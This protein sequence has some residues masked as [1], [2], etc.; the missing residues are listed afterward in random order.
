MTYYSLH[1]S[2]QSD[3]MLGVSEVEP[4]S[5]DS[6]GHDSSQPDMLSHEE[7]PNMEE[8]AGEPTDENPK[9]DA[10]EHARDNDM[11]D[12]IAASRAMQDAQRKRSAE[13][14]LQ[15]TEHTA[16]NDADYAADDAL[17]NS[18]DDPANNQ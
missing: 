3:E 8:Q 14:E 6:V 15:S 4:Q 13:Q 16:M 17:G 11:R 10:A 2:L 7:K 9:R 12:A 5:Q 1:N 18:S